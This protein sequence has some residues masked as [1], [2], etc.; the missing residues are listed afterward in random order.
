MNATTYITY[1]FIAIGSIFTLN[2]CQPESTSE[3]VKK[4][5]MIREKQAAQKASFNNPEPITGFEHTV[6]FDVMG[7][8]LVVPYGYLSLSISPKRDIS[9]W[10]SDTEGQD[11]Y[12]GDF[13]EMPCITKN[14]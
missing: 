6:T 4:L 3:H 1:F 7:T 9:Q 10:L 2:A 14:R 12:F 13:I 5:K 8:K 11:G